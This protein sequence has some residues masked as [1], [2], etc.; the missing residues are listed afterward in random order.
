[1]S[2]WSAT[3]LDT[4]VRVAVIQQCECDQCSD[5]ASKVEPTSPARQNKGDGNGK[6]KREEQ[7]NDAQPLHKRIVQMIRNLFR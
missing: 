6:S 2:E 4:M 7:P 1:M 5:S 3:R